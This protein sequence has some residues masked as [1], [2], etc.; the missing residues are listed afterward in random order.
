MWCSQREGGGVVRERGREGVEIG[1]RERERERV[2]WG[3]GRK[4]EREREWGG[5]R[6][7]EREGGGRGERERESG[8]AKG[9]KE[10]ER[11]LLRPFGWGEG[12]EEGLVVGR[13]G[14]GHAWVHRP[15]TRD[16]RRR[17]VS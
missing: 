11:D 5:E 14:G 9:E 17:S 6:G 3:K 4:R 15:V 8:V 2:G 7:R 1:E 13:E 12:G 16:H 10:R